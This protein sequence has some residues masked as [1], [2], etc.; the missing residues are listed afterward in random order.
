MEF[1]LSTMKRSAIKKVLYGLAGALAV[2]LL[3]MHPSD[4]SVMQL[5]DGM[6]HQPY[7]PLLEGKGD[8]NNMIAGAG[9]N[10][11]SLCLHDRELPSRMLFEVVSF[12]YE[13]AVAVLED[14]E[15]NSS[16]RVLMAQNLLDQARSKWEFINSSITDTEIGRVSHLQAKLSDGISAD[17]V[18]PLSEA[19]YRLNARQTKLLLGTQSEDTALAYNKLG[20]FLGKHDRW[21][22]ARKAFRQAASIYKTTDRKDNIGRVIGSVGHAALKLGDFRNAVKYSKKAIDMLTGALGGHHK[23]TDNVLRQLRGSLVAWG[24]NAYRHGDR[25][26]ALEKLREALSIVH[27]RELVFDAE[28]AGVFHHQAGHILLEKRDLDGAL[29]EM[30]TSV[31]ILEPRFGAQDPRVAKLFD[32][33]AKILKS[34]G[35][36]EEALSY[37]ERALPGLVKQVGSEHVSVMKLEVEMGKLK[38]LTNDYEGASTDFSE[39]LIIAAREHGTNSMEVANLHYNIGYT[40]RQAGSLVSAKEEYK[41]A[42]AIEPREDFRREFGSTIMELCSQEEKQRDFEAALSCLN[43]YFQVVQ[44]LYNNMHHRMFCLLLHFS[45]GE[46][47]LKANDYNAAVDQY[48]KALSNLDNLKEEGALTGPQDK[49]L[50]RVVAEKFYFIGDMFELQSDYECA[51]ETLEDALTIYHD[52]EDGYEYLDAASV[53]FA[54]GNAL[55]ESGRASEA[56]EKYHKAISIIPLED[57]YDELM[58]TQAARAF[59]TTR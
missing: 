37:F 47:Y 5:P 14:P 46:L 56:I 57:F 52:I 19:L 7:A 1:S 9:V 40:F 55:V 28:A 44:D 22:E 2:S 15:E 23:D 3:V 51:L 21:D 38:L 29:V 48:K 17:D 42:I 18:I 34:M 50:R 13:A 59:E 45:I 58:N 43:E 12:N 16:R 10:G 54:M 53:F 39:A 41:A 24:E 8:C 33:V 26:T 30:E 31:Q 20:L 27:N 32:T 6:R 35:R 49:E 36:N 25:D 4:D 11:S